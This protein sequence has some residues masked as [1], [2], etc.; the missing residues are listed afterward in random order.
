MMGEVMRLK[1][2]M[3]L[4]KREKVERVLELLHNNNKC[5][6]KNCNQKFSQRKIL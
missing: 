2:K 1:N 5:G 3:S 6:N 4:L